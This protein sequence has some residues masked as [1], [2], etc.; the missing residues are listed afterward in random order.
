M[1]SIPV[2]E[3]S[4]FQWLLGIVVALLSWIG[5]GVK[6]DVE[7][8]KKS[9]ADCKLDLANFKTEVAHNYANKAAMTT[10]LAGIR[11]DAKE[12]ANRIH[13]RIDEV[14]TDIKTLLGR[15]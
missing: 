14:S 5:R 2:G 7:T 12:S 15:K 11:T 4:W 3:G 1:D 6:G 8:L 13:D 9:D 10:E